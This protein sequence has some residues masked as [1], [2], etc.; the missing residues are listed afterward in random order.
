MAQSFPDAMKAAAKAK[1]AG[2]DQNIKILYGCEGYYVNDVD[3]RIV[4][5]GSGDMAFTDEF[6]AF[7][8][9]TTGLSSKT[10]RIIEIGAVLMKD[11]KELDRFQTFVDPERQLEQKIVDLTGITDEMLRGA[12]KI[13]EILPE[14]LKFVGNRVVV[15]QCGF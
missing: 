4:V 9:E 5:H 6:V 1:V 13:E 10:D 14:F 2:T 11:G 3:D 8:L 12:P 7:D 15:A